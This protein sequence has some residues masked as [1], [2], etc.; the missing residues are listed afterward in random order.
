MAARRKYRRKANHPWLET[1]FVPRMSAAS[2]FGYRRRLSLPHNRSAPLRTIEGLGTPDAT[3]GRAA[4]SASARTFDGQVAS[5]RVDDD[6]H[7]CHAQRPRQAP[8][9]PP[10][11]Q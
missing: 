1:G 11:P 9:R 2:S 8:R 5:L 3:T 7:G 4:T 10:H 6:I